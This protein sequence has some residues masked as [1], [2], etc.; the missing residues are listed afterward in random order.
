MLY[1]CHT[2]GFDPKEHKDMPFEQSPCAKCKLAREYY[3]T[4][5]AIFFDSA[6]DAD[7]YVPGDDEDFSH[8]AHEP[9]VE[10]VMYEGSSED[11]VDSSPVND[12]SLK[13]MREAI[14]Q[15]TYVQLSNII[16]RLV[17]EAKSR[18]ELFEVVIKSMQFPHMSYS[19]IGMSM[20]PKITKQRVLYYL[21]K[22]IEA[23]PELYSAMSTDTRFS[24]GRNAL[25]T[26]AQKHRREVAVEK[27][28][29]VL[30]GDDPSLKAMAL[31]DVNEILNAPF[32]I[33]DDVLNFNWYSEDEDKLRLEREK[34]KNMEKH[35]TCQE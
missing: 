13:V 8:A 6:D 30:Y 10:D 15:Q 19:D 9:G 22:A 7:E 35:G 3:K 33:S 21:K 31:K 4:P 27:L 18:P 5:K 32:L 34:L 26:V 1:G 16:L 23:F 17:R 24:A 20:T 29:G 2:C 25:L 11:I 28:K 14:E 12:V